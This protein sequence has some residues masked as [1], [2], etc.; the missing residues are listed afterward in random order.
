MDF[1]KSEVADM[2][3]KIL[4]LQKIVKSIHKP[5]PFISFMKPSFDLSVCSF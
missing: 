5:E 1:V 3:K 4:L 2:G